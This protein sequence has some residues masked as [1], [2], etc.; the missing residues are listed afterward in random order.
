MPEGTVE[1]Y[2]EQKGF[3]YIVRDDGK[4]IFFERE[5]IRIDGYKTLAPGDWVR[6]DVNKTR[7]GPESKDFKKL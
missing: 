7:Q 3:G 6:F 2:S 1:K 4:M 5:A